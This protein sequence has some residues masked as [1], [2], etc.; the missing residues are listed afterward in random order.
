MIK[1]CRV[2]LMPKMSLLTRLSS[3]L[4]SY[5]YGDIDS[6]KLSIINTEKTRANIYKMRFDVGKRQSSRVD[7]E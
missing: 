1:C 3:L 6:L 4:K 5:C 7:L 2:K